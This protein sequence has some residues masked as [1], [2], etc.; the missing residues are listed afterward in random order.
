MVLETRRNRS[1]EKREQVI[2]E[3]TGWVTGEL[4]GRV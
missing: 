4:G 3:N 1:A 2:E